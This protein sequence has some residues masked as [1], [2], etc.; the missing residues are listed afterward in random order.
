VPLDPEITSPPPEDSEAIGVPLGGLLPEPGAQEAGAQTISI[1]GPSGFGKSTAFQMLAIHEAQRL[2]SGTK[3]RLPIWLPA[4]KLLDADFDHHDPM[5]VVCSSSPLVNEENTELLDQLRASISSSSV[6]PA[7]FIDAIDQLDF[8]SM[9]GALHDFVRLLGR[10]R[11]QVPSCTILL[12]SRDDVW[13]S[14]SCEGLRRQSTC[15]QLQSLSLSD[16][17]KYIDACAAQSRTI[18]APF[19]AR[20]TARIAAEPRLSRLLRR[21]LMLGLAMYVVE[22]TRDLPRGLG[23]I[24]DELARLCL[25]ETSL[26]PALGAKIL[27]SIL[28]RAA[29]SSGEKQRSSPLESISA[30]ELGECVRAVLSGTD[31]SSVNRASSAEILFLDMAHEGLGLYGELAPNEFGFADEAFRLYFAG[32]F[33]ADQPRERILRAIDDHSECPELVVW[34]QSCAHRGEIDSVVVLIDDLVEEDTLPYLLI[35]GELLSAVREPAESN[36]KSWFR[37]SR[38]IIAEKLHR[39]RSSKGVAFRHRVRA[40]DALATIGDPILEGLPVECPVVAVPAGRANIGST[41]SPDT[42]GDKPKYDRIHWHPP[43][44]VDLDEFKIGIHPVTNFE[45]AKFME[46]AGYNE[47]IYWESSEA[48]RWLGQEEAF[49]DQ[50]KLIVQDSLNLHYRKDIQAGFMSVVDYHSMRDEFVK[51]LL[52]RREPLLWFDPR[53]NR[54]NQ[55]VVGVNLWEAKA[56]CAWLTSEMRQAGKIPVDQECRLPSEEEWEYAAGPR[57]AIYPWGQEWDPDKCHMRRADWIAAAVSIGTFQWVP[58]QF[59]AQDMIGN[60]FDMTL[61]AAD[62]YR[63]RPKVHEPT[64]MKEIVTRGGSWLATAEAA[65]SIRFR[66]WDPPCNAYADQSFRI[67]VSNRAMQ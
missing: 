21:P 9:G 12:S 59:G 29:W 55:P 25:N 50:L 63:E 41:I 58:S 48:Q 36:R 6:G 66:S 43:Y 3:G 47:S 65:R 61:S 11:S 13:F 7:I 18:T 45:Y 10:L 23:G 35:A 51:K 57:G 60:V 1:V 2:L 38:A 14:T 64:G 46:A 62:E 37:R 53:F 5:R 24:C 39:A 34:A 8:D 17:A 67:V 33:L 44:E 52:S 26:N 54:P 30:A 32:A 16:I 19:A 40:G 56:Y 31:R 4:V 27:K 20:L 42:I 49:L 28:A 22:Q 15:F